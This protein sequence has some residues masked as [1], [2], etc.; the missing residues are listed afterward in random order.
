MKKHFLFNVGE[1]QKKQYRV[2]VALLQV[3]IFLKEI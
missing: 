2:C 1:I 3:I